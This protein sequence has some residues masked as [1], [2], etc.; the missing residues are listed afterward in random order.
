MPS[1][2]NSFAPGIVPATAFYPAEEEHQDYHLKNPVRY[3]F[4]RSRCGR[5]ARLEQLWG[6]AGP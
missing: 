6:K 2:S 1:S 4:Y 3:T 5:D